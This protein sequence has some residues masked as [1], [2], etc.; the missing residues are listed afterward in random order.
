VSSYAQDFWHIIQSNRDNLKQDR[1][2]FLAR[3][4][5]AEVSD[6]INRYSNISVNNAYNDRIKYDA[7]TLLANYVRKHPEQIECETFYEIDCITGEVDTSSW[8]I[9]SHRSSSLPFCVSN[10]MDLSY[11]V[12]LANCIDRQYEV[13]LNCNGNERKEICVKH[14]VIGGEYTVVN[15][16]STCVCNQFI[17]NVKPLF[18]DNNGNKTM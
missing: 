15:N 14:P 6:R 13:S 8:A 4:I 16:W 18:K 5:R 3:D 17:V 9:E 10:E 1:L 11:W 7:L 12:L 2:E